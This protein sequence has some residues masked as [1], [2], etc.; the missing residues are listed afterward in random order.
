M[1]QFKVLY[2]ECFYKLLPITTPLNGNIFM[3]TGT[4]LGLVFR[5]LLNF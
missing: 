4:N 2:N 1:I 5:D 3:T